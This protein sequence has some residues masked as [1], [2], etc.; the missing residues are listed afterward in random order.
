MRHPWECQKQPLTKMTFRRDGK[1][2]S[3][4]PG[5]SRRCKRNRYPREWRTR[6]TA[7]SGAVSL[8]RIRDINALLLSGDLLSAMMQNSIPSKRDGSMVHYYPCSDHQPTVSNHTRGKSGTS[9]S[10]REIRT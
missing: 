5:K 10:L 1:T 7:T 2:M 3:G 6:R 8:P 9:R 4:V